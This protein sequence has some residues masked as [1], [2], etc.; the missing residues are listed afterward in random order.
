MS[1]HPAELLEQLA[2]IDTPT[3]CNALE[4]VASHRRG[5]GYTVEPLVCT[6]PELGVM[7]G[8][9][10]H[11]HDSRAASGG[12]SEYDPATTTTISTT[13]GRSPRSP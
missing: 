3:V 2:T 7:V 5:F 8:Y 13:A 11:R 1:E 9:A 6:R 12:S 10:P 4:V